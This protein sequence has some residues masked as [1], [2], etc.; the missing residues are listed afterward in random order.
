MLS[1]KHEIESLNS[2]WRRKDYISNENQ[3]KEAAPS[4]MLCAVYL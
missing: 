4:P 1:I 3:H 2:K